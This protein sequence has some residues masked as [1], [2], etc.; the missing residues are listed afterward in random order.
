MSE[1]YGGKITPRACQ[2]CS[3]CMA[4]VH[5]PA[6]FSKICQ[7]S[8]TVLQL[9]RASPKPGQISHMQCCQE[10]FCELLLKPAGGK[11]Y[12]C[13]HLVRDAS[14]SKV[15]FI[16]HIF[17]ASGLGACLCSES[18]LLQVSLQVQCFSEWHLP[19]PFVGGGQSKTQTP[20]LKTLRDFLTSLPLCPKREQ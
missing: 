16:S 20:I 18:V 6:F 8:T 14:I 15:V 19:G 9:G 11:I 7:E 13:E 17:N 5:T 1:S 10:L 2:G 12:V 3:A 4:G